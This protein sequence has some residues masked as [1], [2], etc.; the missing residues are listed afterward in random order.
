MVLS[1]SQR[2]EGHETSG[3][4]LLVIP[5]KK[6]YDI[7]NSDSNDL[8]SQSK[9]FFPPQLITEAAVSVKGCS[10]CLLKYS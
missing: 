2:Q 6:L 1:A 5:E 4:L 8:S 9:P 3:S 7:L 10:K